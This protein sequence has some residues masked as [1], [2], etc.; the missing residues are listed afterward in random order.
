[1]M[2]SGFEVSSSGFEVQSSG[3]VEIFTATLAVYDKG[4]EIKIEIEETR[5]MNR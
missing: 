4:N 1:M 2:S 5:Y 3:L